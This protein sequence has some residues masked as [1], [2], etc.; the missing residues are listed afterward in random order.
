MKD[1]PTGPKVADKVP[2]GVPKNWSKDDVADAIKDYETSIKSRKLEVEAFDKVGGG[3]QTQ[4][5]AHT[6][7]ITEEENFLSS[8]RKAATN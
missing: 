8:L 7:R 6:S 5:L 2:D 3:S 1:S 4:R